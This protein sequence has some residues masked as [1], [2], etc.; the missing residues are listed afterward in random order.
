MLKHRTGYLMLAGFAAVMVVL[1]MLDDPTVQQVT[2][3]QAT[4]Q[5]Q[6]VII[7]F[8]ELSNLAQIYGLEVQDAAAGKD[9][10]LMRDSEGLWYAPSLGES[11][12]NI[13]ADQIN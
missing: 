10:L 6:P 4:Q 11:S 13:T 2:S 7:L 12:G 5:S 9:I 8:P 3:A 1:L